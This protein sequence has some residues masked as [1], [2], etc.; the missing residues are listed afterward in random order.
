MQASETG[1]WTSDLLLTCMD[2]AQVPSNRHSQSGGT[3]GRKGVGLG[4]R[5][6]LKA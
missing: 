2:T 6:P 4:S 3:L 5:K 1:E